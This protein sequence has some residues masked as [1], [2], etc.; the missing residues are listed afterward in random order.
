[1][2]QFSAGL[3]KSLSISDLSAKL[4]WQSTY[5]ESSNDQL[6]DEIR[7]SRG[8]VAL[9]NLFVDERQMHRGM[10][11]PWDKTKSVYVL[12]AFHSLHCLVGLL[13]FPDGK[14][15]SCDHGLGQTVSRER[16]TKP[17]ESNK[18][19]QSSEDEC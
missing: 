15:R 18:E 3:G 8:I 4:E 14:R 16:K 2:T 7:V 10:E 11:F 6:W 5:N 1:M 9:D 19:E 12:N 17:E 13:T